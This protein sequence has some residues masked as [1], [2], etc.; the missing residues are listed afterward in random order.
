[1]VFKRLLGSIGVGAPT[2]DTVLEGGAVRPGGPLRGQVQLQGGQADFT[3]QHITLELVVRIGAPGAPG[4]GGDGKNLTVFDRGVVA[5]NFTLPQ[6]ALNSVPFELTLP[7]QTPITQLYGQPLGV[8]LGVRTELAIAAARDQGDLDMFAVEP[9]PAQEAVLEALGQEGFGF[10]AAA[11]VPEALP[12][13]GQQMPFYQEFDLVPPERFAHRVA[14]LEMTFLP[15][16]QGVEVV[17]EAD[18]RA[19]TLP[20]GHPAGMLREVLA[21][22]PAGRDWNAEVLGW[23]ERLLEGREAA[24]AQFAAGMHPGMQQPGMMPGM[25]P[26]MHPGMQPGMQPGMHPG[27]AQPQRRGPG[28][29]TAVAAGAAG[30]AAGV[31]GGMMVNQMMDGFSGDEEEAADEGFDDGGDDG[32]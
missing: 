4:A 27:M 6:G 19:G 29:G 5:E 8:E 17:L 9:L 26:G 14:E 2:V 10:A 25:Q 16:P 3:I 28:V 22:D 18:K 12:G 20:P 13:T 21:H 15:N 1:M 31:V 24:V 23:V 30:L 11:L 7:W 32:E